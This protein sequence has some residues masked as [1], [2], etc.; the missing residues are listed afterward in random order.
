MRRDV[1][2]LLLCVLFS[3]CTTSSQSAGNAP[4]SVT[5]SNVAM[6]RSLYDAFGRGDVPAVLAG[7][8]PGIEWMEAENINY[9]DRSPYRGPQAVVEGVFMRIGQDWSNFRINVDKFVDGGDTVVALGRYTGTNKTTGKPL[10]AQFA[11][12]WSIRD[13]KIVR[14]QQYADTAQ[15]A[16]VTGVWK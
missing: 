13:G 9:A 14:F 5:N 3:A 12:V 16:R 4:G 8:D 6:M 11:H 1:A 10:D 2:V 7:F 15:F